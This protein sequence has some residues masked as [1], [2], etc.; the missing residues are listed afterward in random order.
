MDV[1]Q[2]IYDLARVYV[3]ALALAGVLTVVWLFRTDVTDALPLAGL[4]FAVGGFGA[5]VLVTVLLVQ[6]SR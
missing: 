2:F 5:L 3:L 4:W 1:G 6:Y